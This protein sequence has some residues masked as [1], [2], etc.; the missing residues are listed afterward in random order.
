MLR[1]ASRCQHNAGAM[2][3]WSRLRRC[4]AVDHLAARG[5]VTSR[6]S[7]ATPCEWCE[8]SFAPTRAGNRF[9]GTRCRQAAQ[10]FRVG[11][12]GATTRR[13]M[14]FAYFD[15]PYPGLARKYYDCPEVDHGELILGAMR[16]YPDGWALSTSADALHE[17][18]FMIPRALAPR[19][20]VWDRVV[21]RRRGIVCFGASNRWE[22]LIVV[23]GRRLRR[24]GGDVL[25]DVLAWGGRQHSHPGALVGMKPAAFCEWMFRHLGALRGD[26][27]DDPF[28]GSGAVERAWRLYTRDPSRDD[29]RVQR[30][31]RLAG[32]A[33]NDVRR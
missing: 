31:S 20:A 25:E 18:M 5:I 14:R 4:E 15:P 32:V 3:L 16:D 24:S 10:R 12:A 2:R 27:L 7:G 21:S 17:V 29:P 9:C 23:G 1:W 26:T 13:P 30:P 22:P 8:E 19:V 6:G 11:A 28:K 33:R